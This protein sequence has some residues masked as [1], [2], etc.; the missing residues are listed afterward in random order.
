MRYNT[1]NPVGTDGSSDPRDLYDN[2]GVI[3]VWASDRERRSA[4]DRLGVERKTLWGME[5]D[6]AEFLANQGFEPVTLVYVDGSELTVDRPT[7]LIERGDNLYSIKLPASFPVT[8]SGTWASDQDLLVAQVDR[9]LRSDLADS[10]DLSK[11]AASV[12]R[13]LVS[14]RSINQLL[15][16]P[17]QSHLLYVTSSYR[18]GMRKG[19]ASYQWSASTPK[20]SHNGIDVVSP[21]VPLADD[22][23]NLLDFLSGTGETQPAGSGCFLLVY[24]SEVTAFQAGLVG[25][26]VTDES[27]LA[28]R[29]VDSRKG[30]IC[31]FP[32]RHLVAGLVLD[33][34]S[35]DNTT[36][37]VPESGELVVG[38][39]PTT[40]SAN[41]LSSWVGLGI[42][43]CSGVTL[44][45]R[46][47]GNRSNQPDQEHVFN[48]RL[49]GVTN[50]KCPFFKAREIRGDGIYIGQRDHAED[51]PTSSDLRFGYFE[52]ESTSD[53]GRNA[54]SI[55]AGAH[56]E[57]DVFRSVKVGALVG[58]IRQ[59][60][61]FDI[62]PNSDFQ[63]VSD[64]QIGQAYV[65][66]AGNFGLQVTGRL[67]STVGGNVDGVTIDSYDVESTLDADSVNLVSFSHC[68]KIRAT[69]SAKVP[70]N[71]T[72]ANVATLSVDNIQNADIHHNGI[73]GTYG[74][75]VATTAR[76]VD[77]DLTLHA[78]GYRIA[79]CQTVYVTRSNIRISGRNGAAG[80]YGLHTRKLTRSGINQ[81]D[82][83]YTVDCPATGGGGT[84][85]VYNEPADAMTFSNCRLLAG[86]LRGYPDFDHRVLGC[87][88]GFNRNNVPEVNYA[89]SIPT[90]GTWAQGD[91]VWRTTPQLITASNM[92]LLGWSRL[93][94]GSANVSGTD[95]ANMYVSHVQPA[96]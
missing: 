25:D 6:V 77:L 29:F 15:I 72:Y 85:G 1:G 67:R 7:Q 82:V 84:Y 54:M 31:V 60:G 23:S 46:G 65:R 38:P 76:A 61:G 87:G 28:Q 5:Q 95:W 42:R 37:N 41:F 58:G 33:G 50:F 81:D 94:T 96:T 27:S 70:T 69:G 11:G 35:Y 48:V 49:A 30:K 13:A 90:N 71:T 16:S 14:I 86:N 12:G 22:Y 43:D 40:S 21:T 88:A 24:P 19:G 17:Q 57:I 55:I 78:S 73:G 62:E 20:S 68:K 63:T 75:R 56:I 91:I 26:G 32:G 51:S 44:N 59:P 93:T 8:L 64:V 92:T 52:C 34:S 10:E 80:S 83:E 9:S 74:A 4:P 47:H 39:R 45:Y 2:A 18:D 3:D 36:I 79:G 66:T 53:D 89:S